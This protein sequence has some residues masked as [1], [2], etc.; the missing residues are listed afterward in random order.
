MKKLV[1]ASNNEHK[2]EEIKNILSKFDLEV[3]SLKEVGINIDIEET[4]T[5]FM[6]NAYIKASEIY[7]IVEDAMVLADDSGLMVDALGGAPGVYSARF[8]GEHGNYKKNNEKLLEMLKGISYED[9]KAKFVCAMV[10]ILDEERTIKVQGEV[11]GVI[12]D[13][14]SGE[15]GFGYDPLFYVPEYNMTFAQMDGG[16]KNKISHRAN[17]LRALEDSVRSIMEE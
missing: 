3:L 7:K 11:K 14:E 12:I 16:I 2:I 4:G 8:A 10:L 17:A 1:V 13:K 15:N 9:R 6:E 5:T